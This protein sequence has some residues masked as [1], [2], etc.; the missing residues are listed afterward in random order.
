MKSINAFGGYT[1]LEVLIVMIISSFMFLIASTFISGKQQKTEFNQGVRELASRI[2]D[3][4]QQVASGRYSDEYL[5]CSFSSGS[6]VTSAIASPSQGTNNNC[7][8]LGKFM[9][10]SENNDTSYEIFT[11]VG[12]RINSTTGQP[13][14]NLIDA[15]PAAVAAPTMSPDLTIQQTTPESLIVKNVSYIPINNS[16]YYSS[17]AF[18]FMQ[19]LGTRASAGEGL[20]TSGQSIIMYYIPNIHAHGSPASVI[21]GIG[22][23]LQFR[24]SISEDI[25]VTDNKYSADIIIGG[26]GGSQLNVITKNDGLNPCIVP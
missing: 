9:H 24:Q 5:S 17:F 15:N 8:F 18:G 16:S 3:V 12:G 21:S 10:L 23:N 2:Q 6:P 26:A 22:P 14:T 20:V 7:E 4:Y 1:I 11:V 13:I 19:S 25:C